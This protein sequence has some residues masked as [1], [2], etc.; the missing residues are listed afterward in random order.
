MSFEY[1]VFP[2]EALLLGECFGEYEISK[3]QFLSY[4]R[5]RLHPM[6]PSLQQ[7]TIFSPVA[8]HGHDTRRLLLDVLLSELREDLSTS[9]V[10][11]LFGLDACYEDFKH[12]LDE[13]R[14]MC[15]INPDL[16]EQT[17]QADKYLEMLDVKSEDNPV[18]I[19]K[20]LL[21]AARSSKQEDLFQLGRDFGRAISE[22]RSAMLSLAGSPLEP[23]ADDNDVEYN[24]SSSIS[25]EG[26]ARLA[27]SDFL[28]SCGIAHAQISWV[29]RLAT[30]TFRINEYSYFRALERLNQ[31]ESSLWLAFGEVL[32]AV[33]E[34]D[35][36]ARMEDQE[37]AIPRIHSVATSASRDD[38]RLAL[39]STER[40][41]NEPEAATNTAESIIGDLSRSVEALSKRLWGERAISRFSEI[42]SASKSNLYSEAERRF[43]GIAISLHKTYR[44][45][46]VHEMDKFRCTFTEARYFAA[47]IRALLELSD[48]ILAGRGKS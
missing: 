4:V 2:T 34:V 36:L 9:Q 40:R 21:D 5:R 29:C 46:A 28:R 42:L 30:F 45:I 13:V 48:Q 17:P 20:L 31:I 26:L 44:N 38:V 47:G 10:D 23:S 19:E 22:C 12:Q 24:P 33:R 41:L 37:L 25:T 14:D 18:A 35:Q 15:S 11:S 27:Q 7:R 1:L 16:R 3:G 6:L 43:A 8:S 39:K 32:G